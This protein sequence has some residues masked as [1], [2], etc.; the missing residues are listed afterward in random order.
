M[1]EARRRVDEILGPVRY[2]PRCDEWLPEDE[3]FFYIEQRK[4]SAN[5]HRTKTGP[6]YHCICCRAEKNRA[7]HAR[8][9]ARQSA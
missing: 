9:R 1:T 4:P 5:N 6:I 2:C 7:T 3:E 8:S